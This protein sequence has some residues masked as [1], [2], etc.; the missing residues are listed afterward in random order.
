MLLS[1]LLASIRIF[2]CIF[3][4]FLVMVTNFFIIPVAREKNKGKLTL[5]IPA[6]VPITLANEIIGA[7]PV[8]ALKTIKSCL[9]SQKL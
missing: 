1:L 5:A 3:F 7:P 8:V 4:F 2:S 6:S 9:C